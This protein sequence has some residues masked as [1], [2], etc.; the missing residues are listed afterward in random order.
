MPGIEQEDT[1]RFCVVYLMKKKGQ[2]R[3]IKQK[4]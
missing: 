4:E 1:P 2:V 3:L